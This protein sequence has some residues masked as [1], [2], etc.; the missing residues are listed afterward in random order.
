MDQIFQTIEL[1]SPEDLHQNFLWKRYCLHFRGEVEWML[2]EPHA[3][4]DPTCTQIGFCT[5]LWEVDRP[6]DPIFKKKFSTNCN[7]TGFFFLKGLDIFGKN[8]VKFK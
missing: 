4:V 5:H 8:P 1:D 2:L 7:I 6:V 3:N